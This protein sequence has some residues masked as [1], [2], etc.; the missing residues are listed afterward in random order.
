VNRWLNESKLN[1]AEA[2]GVF[3]AV[4]DALS[5]P[6]SVPRRSKPS[7]LARPDATLAKARAD[8]GSRHDR[9]TI[10]SSHAASQKL[11]KHLNP[12]EPNSKFNRAAVHARLR[13]RLHSTNVLE[14]MH[15]TVLRRFG[16]GR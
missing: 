9:I 15:A 8:L 1:R 11:N 6:A 4:R 3:R 2:N 14:T 10:A 13:S 5:S 16:M 7:E 12:I